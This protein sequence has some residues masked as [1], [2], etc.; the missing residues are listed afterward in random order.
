VQRTIVEPSQEEGTILV[1]DLRGIAVGESDAASVIAIVSRAMK[2]QEAEVA[3]QEGEVREIIGHRL[4]S[5]FHGDRGVI[6][7]IRA[8]RAINE[9]IASQSVN[10]STLSI[11]VGIATGEFVTG[12]IALEQ[13]SG[14]AL[15]GNAPL[16][17]LLFASH[18]PSGTAYISYETAQTAVGE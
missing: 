4:V 7:A 13:E 5:V 1:T 15:L 2:I 14:L 12:S 18:A 10:G 9:E 8:A 3:R 11:G 16:L 6:H 17:A